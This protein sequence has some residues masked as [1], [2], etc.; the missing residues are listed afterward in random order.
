MEKKL[1]RAEIKSLEIEVLKRYERDCHLYN[2]VPIKK[3]EKSRRVL[4]PKYGN[5]QG[6]H[7]RLSKDIKELVFDKVAQESLPA[8]MI[9]DERVKKDMEELRKQSPY[10][11]WYPNPF[12]HFSRV[13][14]EREKGIPKGILNIYLD[15]A[16]IDILQLHEMATNQAKNNIKP[17]SIGYQDQNEESVVVQEEEI[18][19]ARQESL[20]ENE[21][22][23]EGFQESELSA[24]TL[25]SK[26][27]LSV[28]TETQEALPTSGTPEPPPPKISV[29]EK[30]WKWILIAAVFLLVAA[31]FGGFYLHSRLNNFQSTS[32][33][34]HPLL[35]T[36]KN[37]DPLG[38]AR[39]HEWRYTVTPI[40]NNVPNGP[41][42][43]LYGFSGPKKNEFKPIYDSLC[44]WVKIMPIKDGK[45]V[46]RITGRRMEQW[47]GGH[48]VIDKKEGHLLEFPIVYHDPQTKELFFKFHVQGELNEGYVL[49]KIPEETRP[50]SFK[51]DIW[52]LHKNNQWTKVE[53]RFYK[54][55]L[56]KVF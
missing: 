54:P 46:Y 41:K 15:Y 45:T 4:Y 6:T 49:T 31:F 39:D 7:M 19:D 24:E 3:D 26:E 11:L 10:G 22:N 16:G 23:E 48:N 40:T 56:S 33:P 14:G 20:A 32:P 36:L 2:I 51:G 42:L 13:E 53:I 50:N 1:N 55:R 21:L 47:Q 30:K 18:K 43:L 28:Q 9:R 38:I 35:D 12:A 44:G 25:E 52:Y 8:I 27:V 17:N 5:G 34:A 37:R 29:W